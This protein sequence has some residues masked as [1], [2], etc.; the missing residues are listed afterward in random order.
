[1]VA[2][3]ESGSW[4]LGEPAVCGDAVVQR[5]EACDD[6]NTAGRDLCAPDCSAVTTIPSY[7]R[8][9]FGI[10][11]F[12]NEFEGDEPEV[13]GYLRPYE[14]RTALVFGASNSQLSFGIEIGDVTD[15]GP[16]SGI[17]AT[18]SAAF[19]PCNY[20]GIGNGVTITAFDPDEKRIVGTF[21]SLITCWAN[22]FDCGGE[23]DER[24]YTGEF[25]IHYIV[26]PNQTP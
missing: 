2:D 17:M 9:T 24:T 11:E 22:C 14:G 6:G 10:G 7:G 3:D 16:S 19:Y 5:G 8:F 25:D 15:L 13:Y 18:T 1:V 21:T 4:C 20:N 26:D 12:V 23:G